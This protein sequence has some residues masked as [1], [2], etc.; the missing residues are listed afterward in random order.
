MRQ[1][2][3]ADLERYQPQAALSLFRQEMASKRSRV[4][5]EH[6]FEAP[7]P[8]S[9][10]EKRVMSPFIEQPISKP[11]S[12]TDLTQVRQLL[13]EQNKTH[14]SDGEAD[15]FRQVVMQLICEG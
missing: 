15:H 7:T 2:A 6:S 5:L 14:Y 4:L 10:T 11:A 13:A 12:K 9:F 1:A 8:K 3:Q